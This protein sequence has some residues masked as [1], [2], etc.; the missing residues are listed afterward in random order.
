M[1]ASKLTKFYENI[2]TYRPYER[3]RKLKKLTENFNNSLMESLQLDFFLYYLDKMEA[4]TIETNLYDN[5]KVK[6]FFAEVKSSKIIGCSFNAFVDEYI[7][8]FDYDIISETIDKTTEFSEELWINNVYIE[9]VKTEHGKALERI[10][11]RRLLKMKEQEKEKQKDKE[12]N[13]FDYSDSTIIKKIIILSKLGV[14]EHLKKSTPLGI[15]TNSL[16]SI[17]SSI[18]GAK[19]VSIQPVLNPLINEDIENKNHPFKSE[20]TVKSVEQQLVNLG[21]KLKDN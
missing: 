1:K 16:A 18:T 12:E 5:E 9:T 21:F 4:M 13:L 17:L 7:I 10:N 19:T 3:V 20:K 2:D 8:N 14:L 15:S 6:Y 11:N